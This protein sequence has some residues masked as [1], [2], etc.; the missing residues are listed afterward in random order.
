MD[1]KPAQAVATIGKLKLRFPQVTPAGGWESDL[2]LR[3]RMENAP[4]CL[5]IGRDGK[6]AGMNYLLI[7]ESGQQRLTTAVKKALGDD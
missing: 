1:E 4:R 7:H 2:A 6:I 3:F 5:L